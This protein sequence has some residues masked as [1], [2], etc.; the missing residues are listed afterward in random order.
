MS[1]R[2]QLCYGHSVLNSV[3]AQQ[4][5]PLTLHLA[6]QGP[7]CRL[8]A[9]NA[10]QILQSCKAC[11]SAC[12][13]PTLLGNLAGKCGPESGPAQCVP[14]TQSVFSITA[15]VSLPLLQLDISLA[16]K[17]TLSLGNR[18]LGTDHKLEAQSRMATSEWHLRPRNPA[19]PIVFF[20]EA[21]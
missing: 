7:R 19:N 20:G 11:I 3:F 6:S 1:Q 18:A 8:A 16:S 12:D 9:V 2:G 5:L 21:D 13:V 14:P 10:G 15:S 17:W 4:S